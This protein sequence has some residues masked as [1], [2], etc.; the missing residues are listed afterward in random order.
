MSSK[1]NYLNSEIDSNSFYK[2]VD[3][4]P[5]FNSYRRAC[6][7]G[8]INVGIKVFNLIKNKKIP[9]GDPLLL[10]EI[11]GINAVK[12]TSNI[13]LLCHQINIE[14]V[15]INVFLDDI[16]YSINIYCIV[17]A[18]SKTGV[19]V[20]AMLGVSIGLLTIYDLTK[21][22]NPFISIKDIKLLYKDGGENG[23]IMGSLSSIP[24]SLKKY[25]YNNNYIFN[26]ISVVLV[27]ISDR[28]STN[29]YEDISGKVLF[30]FLKINGANVLDR[31]IIPDDENEISNSLIFFSKKYSPNLIITTGGTGLS[32][33]DLTSNVILKLCKKIVPGFGELLRLNG[34]KY[35]KTS[36]L[37][38]SV[39]GI[40]EKSLIISLP[41]KPSAVIEGLGIIKDLLLHAVDTIKR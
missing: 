34:S 8:S 39:A 19:E 30:D 13:I 20:E 4:S 24:I 23:L 38:C 6:A 35:T 29:R 27:T 41:G 40:Y 11:A 1:Y 28:G 31:I 2:M 7:F 18:Y 26:N 3:I 16:N 9:K 32:S 22:I 17:F 5:K 33:K 12:A 37:S 21:K 25:F 14:N 10:A 15:F 36:W